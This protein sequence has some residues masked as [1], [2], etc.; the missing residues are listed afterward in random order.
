MELCQRGVFA[1]IYLCIGEQKLVI[2]R[3]EKILFYLILMVYMVLGVLFALR[4]PAWQAPDE[5]A[6]YNYMRQVAGGTLIPTIQPGDWDNAYLEQLKAERFKPELLDKLDTVRYENHQPPLYYWIGALVFLLTNGSLT[7]LRLYSVLLG[8]GTVVLTYRIAGEVIPEQPPI[9]IAAMTLVA[10]LP[11]HLAILASVNND[12]LANL[13]IALTLWLCL[14]YVKSDAQITPFHL[15]LCIGLIFITKTTGYFMAGVVLLTLFWRWQQ[16]RTTSLFRP[17]G[18]FAMVAVWFALFWWGRNI[19]VYGFP[20]FLGLRAHDAVVVGQ[21]RTA[22]LI[23]QVG[24][25]E[26]F[27]R[28]ITTTFN[29]F[30]GQFGWMGVPMYDV[31][32]QGS[33]IVYPALLLLGVVALL[34]LVIGAAKTKQ[35]L[36]DGTLEWEIAAFTPAIAR[37]RRRVLQAVT[38]LTVLMYLFYNM[39]FVQWQ[40]R[41]LFPALIPAALWLA[42]GVDAWRRRFLINVPFTYWLTTGIFMLL[43]LLDVYLVWRVLPG[44]LGYT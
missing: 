43:A 20:D 39:T 19:I 4:V 38:L 1:R 16:N 7:A 23:A 28:A 17:V 12:A 33:N 5:P 36:D 6:H 14:R 3:S 9:R 25:G 21:P 34:G 13:L 27:S 18:Q 22:E 35:P 8:L 30:W 31:P 26:Y 40:G 2:S 44:A 29:S 41:Y 10:V 32:A 37:A 42:A 11:Q 24:G 15:G